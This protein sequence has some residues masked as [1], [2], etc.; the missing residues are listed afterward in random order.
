[1]KTQLRK[2]VGILFRHASLTVFGLFVLPAL[3]F[4]EP[5]LRVR[6]G[7]MRTQRIGHLAANT[8]MFFRK[9]QING[10]PPR[11]VYFLFGW[12]PSNRQLFDM[13]LRLRQKGANFRESLWGT[14]LVSSWIPLLRKTR[15]WCPNRSSQAEFHEYSQ[16]KPVVRFTDDEERKGLHELAKM[17]IGPEDWFVC[18]HARDASYLRS[19]RPQYQEY[20]DGKG[21]D[22]QNCAIENYLKAADEIISRG[23]FA[24]RMGAVVEAPLPD[25]GNPGIIDYATK[26]RSDF[27]DIY[28]CSRCRFYLGSSSG[29]AQV[30]IVFD[31]P[32]ILANHVIFNHVPP[33]PNDLMIPRFLTTPDGRRTVSFQEAQEKGYSLWN[34]LG[35][36]SFGGGQNLDLFDWRENDPDDILDVC[37]DMFDNLDGI[38]PSQEAKRLQAEY[39]RRYLSHM[40]GY[41][42][43]GKVGA[44]FA[45]KYK[46]LIV[47]EEVSVVAV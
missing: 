1:M 44:R 45:L 16:S 30:P 46:H 39:G 5:F 34:N 41:E 6:I 26:H 31:R 38:E 19:W 40:P 15:F 37:K 17:G 22:R 7:L 3:Y 42:L 28:L 27:M 18:F 9:L 29:F 43:G 4:L 35:Q 20:W 14:R 23:G 25:T 13:F 36:T 21:I 24:V 47:P 8:E 10:M 33:H 12:D 11:T 32:T 2:L